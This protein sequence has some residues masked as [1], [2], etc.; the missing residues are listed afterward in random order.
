MKAKDLIERGALLFSERR[1]VTTLWQEIAENFYPQ[2]ADFTLS[3]YIGEEF[4]NHLYSSY[5]LLVHRDL[6]SSFAAMLRPRRKDW[7]E[8]GVDEMENVTK[9]GIEWLQWSTKRMKSAMYDRKA[10]FVRS[11][12]EG[13]ADFA[14]FGQ[15]L[16][17]RGIN[18]NTRAPY[19]LYRCW[20]LRDSAWSEMATG[21]SGK[22]YVNG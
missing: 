18:W 3:R 21:P 6:S 11:T 10:N 2:R 13:D 14:A 9:A 4:A 5:P 8:V 12:T 19:L 1:A 20:Q 16:I 22:L 15:C 7:F 17:S